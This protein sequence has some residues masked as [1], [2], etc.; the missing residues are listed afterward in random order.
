[1]FRS[2]PEPIEAIEDHLDAHND[3]PHPLVW[4]ASAE[5]ILGKVTRGRDAPNEDT[6]TGTGH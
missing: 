6:K 4:T 3:E 1:V 2:V 5:S